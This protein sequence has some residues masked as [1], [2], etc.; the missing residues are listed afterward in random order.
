[1]HVSELLEQTRRE[2]S[3]CPGH[4]NVGKAGPRSRM[5]TLST[6]LRHRRKVDRVGIR[7]RGPAFPTFR[8][9]GQYDHSRRVCSKSSDTCMV[10]GCSS[11]AKVPAFWSGMNHGF[12]PTPTSKGTWR[13]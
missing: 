2:W 5:P 6:F 3:Y 7:E 9:P 10:C 11:V 12:D 1:M 8:W 13:S 4:R